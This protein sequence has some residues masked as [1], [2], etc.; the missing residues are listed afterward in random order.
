MKIIHNPKLKIIDYCDERFYTFDGIKYYP[1]STTILSA[2]PK[3]YGFN[4]WLKMQGSNA[5]ELLRKA[6]EQGTII[7]NAI[8]AILNGQVI[9]W[10]NKAG[11]PNFTIDEWKMLNR[12]MEFEN[13]YK[14]QTLAQE[15]S[16]L[17]EE[18][19]FGGTIDR[20]C[21]INGEIWMI[22]YKSSKYIWKSHFLQVASYIA[23]WNRMYPEFKIQRWGL[24]H[25]RANTRGED[26]KGNI[27]QGKGWKIEEAPKER[28]WNDFYKVFHHTKEIWNEENPNYV[29]KNEVFPD[30]L[31][32]VTEVKKLTE[33][34]KT[35][36]VQVRPTIDDR[37]LE[38]AKENKLKV[39]DENVTIQ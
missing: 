10:V 28:G 6:G 12:Y 4:E 13:T 7:H 24:M 17:D 35:Q 32:L 38:P 25:L 26:K 31:Q 3:G 18:L 15:L 29:P 36:K 33:D 2:Y 20:V 21:V 8:D 22:D 37:T 27:I 23:L 16:V 19:G 30:T 1:S 11:T 14:P 5:D 34:K 9:S 39:D